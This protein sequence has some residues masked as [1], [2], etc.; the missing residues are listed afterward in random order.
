MHELS[1]GTVRVVHEGRVIAEKGASPDHERLRPRG[2]KGLTEAGYLPVVVLPSRA[3]EE[4]VDT[5]G[6]VRTTG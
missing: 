1:D 5:T 4:V 6:T 2:R 3:R